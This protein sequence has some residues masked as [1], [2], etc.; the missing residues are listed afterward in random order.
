LRAALM[1]Q[2]EQ[3]MASTLAAEAASMLAR[4]LGA[5]LLELEPELLG[6]Y[7]PH[8]SEFNAAGMVQADAM[9]AKLAKCLPFAQRGPVQ[10]HY[11][12]WNGAAPTAVDDC[13]I[14]ASDGALVQ[15]DVVL[16]PC[17]G[18]TAEGYR[19]GYGSGYF[20]R[21]MARHPHVTAVGVAWSGSGI[22]ASALGLEPH[23]RPLTLIVTER[24]VA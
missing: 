1:A 4:H 2:R 13:G 17:V 5:V 11:R 19:L 12:A 8:R 18:F 22:P 6:L 16:V 21:W 9:L 14:P 23:D 24:G 20:D 3:F 10:M 7:W 15:P